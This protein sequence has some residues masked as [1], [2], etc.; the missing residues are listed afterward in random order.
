MNE[1]TCELCRDLMPLVNDGIASDD[2][3]KA[4]EEHVKACDECRAVFGGEALPASDSEK[5]FDKLKRRL[6]LFP[7]M[8][9]MFGIFFGIGL[10]ASSEMFYNSLIMPVI[11]AL[12]YIIFRQKSLYVLP[13]TLFVTHGLVNILGLIAEP[14]NL[15]SL[16]MWTFAYSL[17]AFL[18]VIIAALLHYAFGKDKIKKPL[19]F[20]ALLLAFALTVGLGVF[21]NG[22]VG[23]PVSKLLVTNSAKAYLAENY[24][25]TDYA[26]ESVDYNFKNGDYYARVKA[27]D[28]LDR[29]FTL[30]YDFCGRLEYDRCG[31][32]T[33]GANTF[34][35]LTSQYRALTDSV[36]KSPSF[37]F[38]SDI[39]F[40]DLQSL[41]NYEVG[42]EPS[43][44]YGIDEK[45]L[46]P[47]GIY[48][49]AKLGAQAGH[50][51]VYVD[52]ET[53][54]VQRAA[55]IMLEIK[56]L[57]DE[58]GVPFYAIDFVLQYPKPLESG[59]QRPDGCVQ[60]MNFLY[61]DIYEDGMTERVK[62]ANNAVNEYYAALDKEKSVDEYS[63][64]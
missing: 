18:G 59:V 61:A 19:K 10:T 49:I 9:M 42:K 35:R 4:V 22:L 28:S 51:V 14:L 62:A 16:V 39:V 23:N 53:V 8:L 31:D 47:D 5:A 1:I 45:T 17:F 56:R 44:A 32:I 26:L 58:G 57:M 36:F 11:G 41:N 48:D 15:S 3:R 37:P 33:S 63:E 29:Y 7:V 25:G 46:Q 43:D 55:E 2:S 21:A 38:N 52:D 20:A 6:R 50:L 34:G 40:G 12:G 60:T 24:A 54:T 64:K 27:P 30:Y 13:V